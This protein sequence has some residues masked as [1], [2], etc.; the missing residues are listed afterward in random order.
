LTVD[1]HGVRTHTYWTYKYDESAPP[2]D[3]P[4]YFTVYAILLDRAVERCMKGRHRI[5]IFLSGGYDSR[6]VAACIRKHHLPVPAFTFGYPHSRD[7]RYAAMLAQRLGLDH[8]PLTDREPY[9]YRHCRSI[10]WRTEGMSPFADVTSIR[11]HPIMKQKI[12]IILTGF[13]SEFSGSHTWP[14]LLLARS[15]TAATKAIFQRMVETGLPIKRKV[16]NS[17]FFKNAFEALRNRF[18]QSFETIQNDHPLNVADCWN[19]V[20]FQPLSTWHSPSVDRHLFEMRA[21]HTDFDLAQ[22]LLTIPPYS[23]LEQRVYKKMIAYSFPKIRSVPCTNSGLPIN[24]NFVQEYVTM[25][26]RYLGRKAATHFRSLFDMQQP[27]GRE[28]RHLADDFRAE[29]ELI[30]NV[31]RPLLR[32]G[33]FPSHM[34]NYSGIEN[35][36]NEHYQKNQDHAAIL[37]RLISW[38]LAVK[39]FLYD[40]LAEVPSDIYSPGSPP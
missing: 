22:F 30:H 28:P 39:F 7:V 38:G 9:L 12:D 6:S 25:A 18:L 31:L 37:S 10:V 13:L 5:G 3:Q 15:R 14:Q 34:F 27:L 40:D 21:P 23:R 26:V 2:L 20:H 32:G 33:I 8:H 36:I 11:Y 16:F 17:P 1:P 4:T 19:F 24:P 35:L 29:P